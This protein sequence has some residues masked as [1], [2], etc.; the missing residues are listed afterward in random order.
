MSKMSTSDSTIVKVQEPVPYVEHC[1]VC[2]ESKGTLETPPCLCKGSLKIHD[3]C[4]KLIQADTMVCKNCNTAFTKSKITF[5]E[6]IKI[7]RYRIIIKLWC[8]I[9]VVSFTIG[10]ALG[11][12]T[13]YVGDT[14]FA[15]ITT[16]LIFMLVIYILLAWSPRIANNILF[17]NYSCRR[18]NTST[19]SAPPLPHNQPLLEDSH[20]PADH[21][22][23]NPLSQT[24]PHHAEP[25]HQSAP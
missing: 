5:I 23:R 24:T 6:R 12:T 21:S 20:T 1:Y 15:L 8:F 2:M 18:P 25:T 16:P 10:T 7:N 19:P 17:C 13:G 22:A 11:K 4:L 9:G 3:A 14:A